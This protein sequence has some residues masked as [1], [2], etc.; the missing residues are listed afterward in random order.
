M[1]RHLPRGPD[2]LHGE[3]FE[4]LAPLGAPLARGLGGVVQRLGAKLEQPDAGAARRGRGLQPILAVAPAGALVD[5]DRRQDRA[6]GHDRLGPRRG[7]LAIEPAGIARTDQ[8]HPAAGHHDDGCQH[9][10]C[11]R[12]QKRVAERHH[13]VFARFASSRRTVSFQLPGLTRPQPGV[14]QTVTSW[15]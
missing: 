12:L 1:A 13:G 3:A 5:D 6:H 15:M 10:G 11:S 9:Y 8:R 14:A 4:P 2:G 7:A